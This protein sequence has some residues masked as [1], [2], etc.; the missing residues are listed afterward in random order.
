MAKHLRRPP[1][2]RRAALGAVAAAAVSVG[3][4][5]VALG[6]M[7]TRSA[8]DAAV[9]AAATVSHTSPYGCA[10]TAARVVHTERSAVTLACTTGVT[11]VGR[12]R[13][14]TSA[15]AATASSALPAGTTPGTLLVSTVLVLARSTVAMTGWTRAYDRVSGPDGLRLSAWY[16][17]AAR[18]DTAARAT[19]E[20]AGR[21]SMITT[22]F[23]GAQSAL[24]VASASDPAVK[25]GRWVTAVGAQVGHAR[26]QSLGGA[27]SPRASSHV[28]VNGDTRLIETVTASAPRLGHVRRGATIT[29]ALSVLPRPAAAVPAGA[30]PLRVGGTT[31]VSCGG[32]TASA[33]AVSPTAIAV[34][35]TGATTTPSTS[36]T[37]SPTT[38]PTTKPTTTVAPSTPTSSSTPPSSSTTAPSSSPTQES[39][40]S[41]A[42]FGCTTSATQGRCGPYDDYAKITGTTSS[43]Y[44]GNNV[45]SSIPGAR[46]TLYASDPGNWRVTANMPAGNTSVV[47]YPSIGANYGQVSN[48]PTPLSRYSSI[49]SSF[50]ET[51]NAT[52]RTSAWAAYDIWL[53]P[54]SCSSCSSFEVMIQ[55]DFANNGDCTVVASATFGGSG[56]VPVQSW[57]L[58]KYGSELIWKLGADE[59]NKLNEQSG[60]VDILSMLNWLVDHGYLPTGTG[61]W[62]IGYGWEI[63]STGGADENFVINDYSLTA[64][65]ASNS[66]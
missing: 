41:Q 2:L 31:T 32:G 33:T 6:Q 44:V 40:P 26:A 14:A 28:V 4:A 37:T 8:A 52:A 60:K 54:G 49:Y 21:V 48:M 66:R 45:W 25:G 19:V 57:H 3:T 1:R 56:G 64:T 53:G 5:T 11:Q 22:D 12:M 20:P 7:G 59:R 35:C 13:S 17:T 16:R 50:S 51:M 27:G 18:G 47:S 36:P 24:S 58:C 34:T 15:T 46:Q 38:T 63:C 61:L 29:G 65:P 30:I 9:S 23:A 62:M 55:H 10:G 42:A 43:T 39:S